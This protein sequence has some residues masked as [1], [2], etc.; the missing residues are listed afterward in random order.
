MLFHLSKYVQHLQDE[1]FNPSFMYLDREFPGR[2]I[3]EIFTSCNLVATIE[4][5]WRLLLTSEATQNRRNS[6]H[7][8]HS[9]TRK[10]SLLERIHIFPQSLILLFRNA[11]A[12]RINL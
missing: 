10:S 7:D 12:S 4:N 11:T 9:I 8:N 1:L 2:V 3:P 5:H 6:D